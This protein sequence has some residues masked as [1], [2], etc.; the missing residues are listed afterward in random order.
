[1]SKSTP[2]AT[3]PASRRWLWGLRI[4][5]AFVLLAALLALLHWWGYRSY[6]EVAEWAEPGSHE[7]FVYEGETYLLAGQLGKNNLTKAKF[8]Q[9]KIIGRVKDGDAFTTEPETTAAPETTDS[10]ETEEG[11]ETE[12]TPESVVPPYGSQWFS[13]KPHTYVLYGVEKKE[14]CLL[15]L[16]A[17]G[18]LYVYYREGTT[19]P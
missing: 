14:D 9:D 15:L 3:A 2:Q 12:T 10:S 1:M 7:A 13:D 19:L 18:A 5:L 17:D 11:E 6:P 4:V 16:E 8:P